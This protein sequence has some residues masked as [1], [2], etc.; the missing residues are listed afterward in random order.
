MICYVVVFDSLDPN[1]AQLLWYCS[2]TQYLMWFDIWCVVFSSGM[3]WSAFLTSFG[4]NSVVGSCWRDLEGLKS[5]SGY[6][7]FENMSC[8]CRGNNQTGSVH[9]HILNRSLKIILLHFVFLILFQ[10]VST[11]N[12][13]WFGMQLLCQHQ[14]MIQSS[15]SGRL[16]YLKTSF[17]KGWMIELAF[18]LLSWAVTHIH[19]QPWLSNPTLKAEKESIISY[20]FIIIFD[21]ICNLYWSDMIWL[22][23]DTDSYEIPR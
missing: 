21:D 1:L 18:A 16:N 19:C 4:I 17:N 7:V 13:F 20:H 9:I 15:I 10:C 2:C 12:D 14:F 5:F 8:P 22:K 23:S 6:Q 3:I 11:N